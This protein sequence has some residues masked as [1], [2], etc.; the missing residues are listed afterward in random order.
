V[1]S[2]GE[3]FTAIF[4]QQGFVNQICG[5][6]YPSPYAMSEAHASRITTLHPEKTSPG[7][8]W[9]HIKVLASHE[10]IGDLYDE[11]FSMTA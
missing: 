11:H 4:T 10:T 2:L 6:L 5:A 1:E 3:R 7:N 9:D 8:G